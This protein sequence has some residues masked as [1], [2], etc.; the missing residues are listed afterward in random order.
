[1]PLPLQMHILTPTPMLFMVPM[2]LAVPR[3][4]QPMQMPVPMEPMLISML[5]PV[6]AAISYWH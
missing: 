6:R 2:V 4:L 3:V 1:M 5:L